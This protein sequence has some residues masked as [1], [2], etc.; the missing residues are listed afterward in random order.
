MLFLVAEWIGMDNFSS[1]PGHEEF[2]RDILEAILEEAGKFCSTE[3][4]P[5]NREG[6]EIG[7]VFSEGHVTT[8]PGFR[9]VYQKFIEN[10]WT[11][12]DAEP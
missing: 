7:A 11:S 8:P 2:D 1:L 12:I 4:L 6:D 3:V 10:G 9:E 5:I